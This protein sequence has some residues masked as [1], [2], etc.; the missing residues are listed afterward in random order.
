MLLRNVPGKYA[1]AINGILRLL[2]ADKLYLTL[3]FFISVLFLKK[4]VSRWQFEI[5][6][7][8][9]HLEKAQDCFYM[10]QNP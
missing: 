3:F 10:I 2:Y 9:H 5:V 1:V 7:A 8:R 6:V 4:A